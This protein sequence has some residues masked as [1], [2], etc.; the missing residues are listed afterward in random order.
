MT[1]Q[2]DDAFV[3]SIAAR[4]RDA[5]GDWI[6]LLA[7]ERDRLVALAQEAIQQRQTFADVGEARLL[8][9]RT[10]RQRLADAEARVR[11]VEEALEASDKSIAPLCEFDVSGICEHHYGG[12]VNKCLVVEGERLVM[13]RAALARRTT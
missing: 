3:K 2:Q 13:R 11:E 7:G 6:S 12:R 10:L 1:A 8:M 9:E 5:G 4:W